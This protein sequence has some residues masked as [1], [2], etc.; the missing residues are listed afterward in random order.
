MRRIGIICA[1]SEELKTL[2][3]SLRNRRTV[4]VK[5][6]AFYVGS[7]YGQPVVIVQS[8]IGKVQAGATAAIMMVRF[9]VEVVINSGSAGGIS[10]KLSVGDLVV[11]TGTAYH[12]VDVTKSGYQFGQLPNQPLI[13]K[14]SP[15]WEDLIVKSSRAVDLNAKRGLIVSGDQFVASRQADQQILR[16]FPDALAC[17]M[18]G[19]AVGQM[20]HQFK[21]P[22][23][24]IRAMSDV[25]D[26]KA[27]VSFD[28]F[29]LRAGRQSAQM[30]LNL[31]RGL[32]SREVK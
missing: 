16:R 27:E 21:T 13:F 20:A 14:A 5:G 31:C 32:Q 24:V 29:I 8:G 6:I 4:N 3:E 11:S 26:Q 28:K 30:L 9:N 19:A 17:E 7:I 25:G 12:D 2:Y 23:V 10:P 15:R 22:Y 1:M 18:E